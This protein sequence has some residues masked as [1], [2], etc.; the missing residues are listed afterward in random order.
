MKKYFLLFALLAAVPAHAFD[1]MLSAGSSSQ[2]EADF[3]EAGNRSDQFSVRLVGERFGIRF[4]RSFRGDDDGNQGVT[5]DVYARPFGG[6]VLAGGL[7]YFKQ[8]LRTLGRQA[9][10]HGLVGWEIRNLIG[11][12]TVGMYYDHWSN[13]RRLFNRD[14]PHNPPRNVFSLGIGLPF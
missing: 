8:P 9:N 14:L 3:G 4:D 6:L 1:L 13:G 11:P 7:S 10:F 5:A 2:I 12:A